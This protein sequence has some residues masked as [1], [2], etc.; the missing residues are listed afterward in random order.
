MVVDHD[1]TDSRAGAA[2]ADDGAAEADDDDGRQPAPAKL[3]RLGVALYAR[4]NHYYRPHTA[5]VQQSHILQSQSSE[6]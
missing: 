4:S 1:G 2:E 5:V 3:E 6:A